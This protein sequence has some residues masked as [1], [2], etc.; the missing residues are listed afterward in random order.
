MDCGLL[1]VTRAG[2]SEPGWPVCVVTRVIVSSTCFRDPEPGLSDSESGHASSVTAWA[3]LALVSLAVREERG[4]YI[5]LPNLK[6]ARATHCGPL[7]TA[8]S[9]S[10][11]LTRSEWLVFRDYW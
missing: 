9:P 6:L 3:C 10:T 5:P 8:V 7:P 2:A 1:R 11:P 4:K